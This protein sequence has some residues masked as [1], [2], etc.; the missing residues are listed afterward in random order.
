MSK[1]PFAGDRLSRLYFPASVKKYLLYSWKSLKTVSKSITLAANP[2]DIG[3]AS[4]VSFYMVAT[5]IVFVQKKKS[6]QKFLEAFLWSK[7]GYLKSSTWISF[8]KKMIF[9]SSSC[10]A[11]PVTSWAVNYHSF[12]QGSPWPCF[13]KI[14]NSARK[15]E[16]VIWAHLAT[17]RFSNLAFTFC[18]DAALFFARLSLWFI[19]Q[20]L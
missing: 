8:W 18:T 4:N 14:I 11:F 17:M 15:R 3:T 2:P 19:A 16:A 9:A 1:I 6:H 12:N 10:F 20:H 7:I 5:K 13:H